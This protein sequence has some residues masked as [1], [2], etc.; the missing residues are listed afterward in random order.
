MCTLGQVAYTVIKAL[1]VTVIILH[2]EE[3]QPGNLWQEV[4]TFNIMVKC[5]DWAI[6]Q[7]LLDILALFIIVY[8]EYRM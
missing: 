7:H 2:S 6:E 4:K 1:Q 5:Y 8:V 3:P